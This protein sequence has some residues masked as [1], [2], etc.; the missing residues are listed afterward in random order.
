MK[1]D[2][3]QKNRSPKSVAITD[4]LV[5]VTLDDDT[6]IGNPLEW[7]PWLRD[8]TPEQQR[9]VNLYGFSVEWPDLDE[10]LDIEGM[11][12]GIKPRYRQ[13]ISQS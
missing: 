8:A 3:Y 6:T 9:N 5:I 11:L 10:G 13:L 12:R 2:E 1:L 7:F 4:S